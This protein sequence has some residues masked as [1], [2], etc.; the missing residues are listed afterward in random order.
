MSKAKMRIGSILLV[1]AMLMTL[2]PVGVFAA[3]EIFEVDGTGYNDF[4]VALTAA[5]G[6]SSKTV[7]LVGSFTPNEDQMNQ[8]LQK[9]VNVKIE[10]G[11]SLILPSDSEGRCPDEY[12]RG[13]YHFERAESA[14]PRQMH[15]D[16][17]QWCSGGNPDRKDSLSA[18]FC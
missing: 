7:T 11:A 14:C 2:L 6:D 5:E 12:Q 9:D 15:L 4:D 1:V 13:L 10:A 18:F 17:V 8:L 3:G 16:F